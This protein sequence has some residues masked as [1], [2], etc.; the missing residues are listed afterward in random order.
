MIDGLKSKPM[1]RASFI[2]VSGAQYLDFYGVARPNRVKD[3]DS[4]MVCAIEPS[5]LNHSRPGVRS[6]AFNGSWC[7]SGLLSPS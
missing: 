4:G 7:G 2:V 6:G 1:G 3:K 5:V